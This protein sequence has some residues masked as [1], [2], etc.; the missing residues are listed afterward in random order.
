MDG[1]QKKPNFA[2][3]SRKYGIYRNNDHANTIQ[4]LK[5]L[6]D[7]HSGK[8]VYTKCYKY[9]ILSQIFC[10]VKQMIV[11]NLRESLG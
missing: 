7:K 2:S 8:N 4:L 3:N 10:T 11:N 1:P 6:L 9:I 5:A